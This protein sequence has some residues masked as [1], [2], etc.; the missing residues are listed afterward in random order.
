MENELHTSPVFIIVKN[1]HQWNTISNDQGKNK[2]PI[3][4]KKKKKK[5]KRKNKLKS[6]EIYTIK[7]LEMFTRTL[8]T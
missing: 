6:A 3:K 5:R 7:K 8:L 1:S 4:K 2:P